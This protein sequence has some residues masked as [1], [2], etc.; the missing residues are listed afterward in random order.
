MAAR[1]QC[2]VRE[3]FCLSVFLYIHSDGDFSKEEVKMMFKGEERAA[4]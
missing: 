1:D 4:T 2:G 3:R